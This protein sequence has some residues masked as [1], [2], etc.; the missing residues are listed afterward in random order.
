[1]VSSLEFYILYT[2]TLTT[3]SWKNSFYYLRSQRLKRLIFYA[4]LSREINE[5]LRYFKNASVC[6]LLYPVRP[7]L[8]PVRPFYAQFVLFYVPFVLFMSCSSSLCPVRPFLCPVRPFLCPI[9]PFYVPFVL[10]YVSFFFW[11]VFSF[12]NDLKSK[13]LR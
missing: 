2:W 3:V 9:R 8:C 1:M 13:C 11:T 7:F 12:V 10:F 6:P 5:S 4:I